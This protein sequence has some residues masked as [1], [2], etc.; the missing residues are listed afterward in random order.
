MALLNRVL[1]SYLADWIR[2]KREI[3]RESKE[4]AKKLKAIQ[5]AAYL[6]DDYFTN[7]IDKPGKHR[8]VDPS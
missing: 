3:G 8:K 5:D 1:G 4:A 2:F 6:D 7:I